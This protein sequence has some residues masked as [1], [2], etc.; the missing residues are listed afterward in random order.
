MPSGMI[1]K[2]ARC[3]GLALLSRGYQSSGVAMRRPSASG[4]NRSVRVKATA[5]AR[6]SPT[7]I[8]KVLIPGARQLIA[9]ALQV[10]DNIAMFVRRIPGVYGNRKVMQPDFGFLVARAYV[11]MRWLPALIGIEESAIRPP[12]QNGRHTSLHRIH[13]R[14]ALLD[15]IDGDEF[16]RHRAGRALVVDGAVRDLERFP[17][18]E[19]LL[20]LSV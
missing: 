10:A 17:G 20:R 2:L 1:S 19:G 3:S 15:D 14:V 16:R 18:L 12:T 4:T 7:S 6:R 11:D 9:M 8:S 13:Q 5:E